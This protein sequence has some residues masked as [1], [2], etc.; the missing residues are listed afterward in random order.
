MISVDVD[1]SALVD[2][3][4]RVL[5]LA[6]TDSLLREIATSMESVTRT[7]IHEQGIK[8][9]GSQ[10]GT[11]SPSYLELRREQ[12]D[13]SNTNVNLVFTGD[14]ETDYK[15]I[16]ISDTEYG[17]GYTDDNNADKAKWIT[18]RYGRIF[19]LTDDELEQVRDIIKEYLNKL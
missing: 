16:P 10:I 19:A 15:I 12:Q 7:R 18:E 17:L 2:L 13:R 4:K 1:V 11:Y 3:K 9:D 8:S 5:T 14:M 6:Q